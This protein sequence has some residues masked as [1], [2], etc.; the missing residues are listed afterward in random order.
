MRS[1]PHA[2]T[3]F[4]F[5]LSFIF[6]SLF[7]GCQPVAAPLEE[8]TLP[9]AATAL[10]TAVPAELKILLTE[11]GAETQ[12]LCEESGTIRSFTLESELLND[13]LTFNVYFPPCYDPDSAHPYPVIYLLHGQRQAA[14]LWQTLGI[15]AVADDLILNQRRQSF[16]IV[17]PTEEYYFRSVKNNRYPDALLTEL[18]PWVET[19]LAACAQKECRAIGGI[20]RG[21]AW[22]TRLAFDHWD[23]FGALGAHSIPLFDGDIEDLPDWVDAIPAGSLPRIY[24][25][26]G[27]SDP[28]LKDAYAFEQA[29]N[30]LGVAHE[31]HLNSGRHNEDYWAEHLPDYLA[32]YTLAWLE[33]SE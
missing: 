24:A 6:A 32:W 28:A 9:P 13:V 19:N 33:G 22:A 31:W 11:D 12:A 14:A 27:S 10:P 30:A 18:L 25:D 21:A 17:M 20:S 26:A 29:L 15:Q 5:P 3:V 4:L 8:P 1:H 7:T 16:L 23:I 2:T